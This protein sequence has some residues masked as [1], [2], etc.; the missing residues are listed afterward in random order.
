LVFPDRG[1]PARQHGM[2]VDGDADDRQVFATGFVVEV[3]QFGETVNTGF[4]GGKPEINQD[5]AA[6]DTVEGDH[7]TTAVG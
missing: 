5:I 4:A 7:L 1:F 6:L 2:T 3:D